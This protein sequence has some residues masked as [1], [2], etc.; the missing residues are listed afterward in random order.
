MCERCPCF[1]VKASESFSYLVPCVLCYL[2]S[3]VSLRHVLV[4]VYFLFYFHFFAFL[5]IIRRFCCECMFSFV[6]HN[7]FEALYSCI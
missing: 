2:T 7:S 3:P 1:P 4:S 6:S 5:V